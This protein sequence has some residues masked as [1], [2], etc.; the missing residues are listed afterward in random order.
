[1]PRGPRLD[2]PGCLHH[3]MLRGIE[4]RLIFYDDHDRRDLLERL[5]RILP[6]A[7]MRC[8][9]WALMPNHV[10]LV[11]RTGPIPLAHVMARVNTGYALAFNLRHARVGHLFQ[12]RYKSILVEQEAQLLALVRY[13]HLNPLRAGLV[14]SL[15]ALGRHRW[16][17]HATLLGRSEASFQD[18]QGILERFGRTTAEARQRLLEWMRAEID[19]EL[20]ASERSRAPEAEWRGAPG[21]RRE[22]GSP[23]ERSP[24][25][26]RGGARR[27]LSAEPERNLPVLIARVCAERDVP[28]EELLGGARV[29]LVAEAR[30]EIVYRACADLGLPG[31]AVARALGLSKAAVSQARVRGRALL[32]SEREES[33]R[34]N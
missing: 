25:E 22:E 2:A 27:A 5:S 14:D 21:A 12:G 30:A 32:A 4:R 11:L 7:G 17:G 31:V 16:T 3:V 23:A 29:R 9:A 33:G 28:E 15:E 18:A 6:E 34:D 13:V 19:P 10:H 20:D 26:D 8:F 1:M 24:Q